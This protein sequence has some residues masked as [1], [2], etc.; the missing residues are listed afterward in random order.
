MQRSSFMV[1]GQLTGQKN[2]IP[3]RQLY[4]LESGVKHNSVKEINQTGIQLNLYAL[5]K[6]DYLLQ[7]NV[8]ITM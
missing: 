7:N 6:V 3:E 4:T 5:Q 2:L 1:L 8:T